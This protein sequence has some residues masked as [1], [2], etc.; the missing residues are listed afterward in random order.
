[1]PY[2]TVIVEASHSLH[3]EF[4]ARV[5]VGFG[6]QGEAIVQEKNARLI[7]K[8]QIHPSGTYERIWTKVLFKYIDEDCWKAV[9]SEGIILLQNDSF[10][11]PVILKF[12]P[13]GDPLKV[14]CHGGRF[15][16]L[17]FFNKPQVHLWTIIFR[18]R[19]LLCS[20]RMQSYFMTR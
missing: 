20:I 2:V 3:L 4:A 11:K 18:V 6:S 1:M 5:N 17:C 12:T 8:Y 13:Q 9:S 10:S 19:K 15:S 7:H 14:R 16:W